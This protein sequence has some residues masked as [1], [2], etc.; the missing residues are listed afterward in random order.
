MFLEP[1]ER[2]HNAYQLDCAISELVAL[3]RPHSGLD[4]P[5]ATGMGLVIG[6]NEQVQRSPND[7]DAAHERATGPDRSRPGKTYGNV[8]TFAATFKLTRLS[9]FV[10]LQSAIISSQTG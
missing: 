9:C 10:R 6:S 8:H 5:L 4:F 3:H 2:H 1:Q 7:G